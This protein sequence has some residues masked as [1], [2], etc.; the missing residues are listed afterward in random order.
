MKR[1]LSLLLVALGSICLATQAAADWDPAFDQRVL[2]TI[3]DFKRADPTM[4]IFFDQAYGYAVFPS[5]GKGAIG[6][7]GAHGDGAVF[8]Q[9]IAIGRASL[10]KVS[11]G[12]QLGGQAYQQIVFFKD[13][14]TLNSLK[15][16]EF[17]LD[18]EASAVAVEKGASSAADYQNGVAVFTMG[19]EGLMFEASVGG[20]QFSYEPRR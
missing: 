8:E 1:S 2:N 16:S 7:G 10:V 12:I 3:E 5:I 20:Q 14:T 13:E 4:Q 17:E 6:I 9:G 11:I 18:A 15:R 19:E